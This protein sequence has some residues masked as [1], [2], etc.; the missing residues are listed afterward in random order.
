MPGF[1]LYT[2]DRRTPEYLYGRLGSPDCNHPPSPGATG[3]AE[4]DDPSGSVVDILK[5][6]PVRSTGGSGRQ[7]SPDSR[8][9]RQ[10]PRGFRPR[11]LFIPR[12][13]VWVTQTRS[14]TSHLPAAATGPLQPEAMCSLVERRISV[15]AE[16]AENH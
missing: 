12:S 9:S 13:S 2:A 3:G 4:V 11:I 14:H 5:A 16:K 15:K 10:R 1:H 8:T 6:D 7:Q